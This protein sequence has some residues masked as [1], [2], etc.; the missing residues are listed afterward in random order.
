MPNGFFILFNILVINVYKYF[1]F[2]LILKGIIKSHQ[3]SELNLMLLL[4]IM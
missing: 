1:T 3:L 2:K 4:L